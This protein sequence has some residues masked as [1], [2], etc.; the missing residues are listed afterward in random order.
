MMM[1]L[2]E[3]KRR[4]SERLCCRCCQLEG[5]APPVLTEGEGVC[6][7]CVRVVCPWRRGDKGKRQDLDRGQQQ[8][9]EES[10]V[11]GV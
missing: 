7:S 10:R 9:C 6:E 2:L 1:L 3:K 5:L 4:V 11:I 8:A